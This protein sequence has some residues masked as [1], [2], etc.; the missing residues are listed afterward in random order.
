[1]P[2]DETRSLWTYNIKQKISTTYLY[3]TVIFQENQVLCGWQGKQ[4]SGF[5]ALEI[6]LAAK[7]YIS[8]SLSGRNI[9]FT[10]KNYISDCFGWL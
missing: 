8:I 2:E 3:I 5:L 6:S 7:Y 1:M 4:A 10:P 9:M